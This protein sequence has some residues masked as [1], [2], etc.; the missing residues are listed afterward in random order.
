MSNRNTRAAVL[1][2]VVF[3]ATGITAITAIASATSTIVQLAYGKAF[4]PS[5]LQR[6]SLLLSDKPQL[7]HPVTTSALYA[8][9][10]RQ[11]TTK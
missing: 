11:E 9:S 5:I 10:I 2:A 3:L 7:L 1:I 4:L 8:G 6:V